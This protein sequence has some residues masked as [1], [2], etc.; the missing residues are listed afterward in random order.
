M[1]EGVGGVQGE[2]ALIWRDGLVPLVGAFVG[3][4]EFEIP[5]GAGGAVSCEERRELADAFFQIAALL[6]LGDGEVETVF[7]SFVEGGGVVGY[8]GAAVGGLGGF[9]VFSARGE[10][11]T[12]GFA[13]LDEM[14]GDGDV[15]D[16]LAA[17]FGHVAV[18]A[19]F[20]ACVAAGGDLL[21][22]GFTVALAAGGV[23]FL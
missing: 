8:D 18:D 17:A 7:G 12:G 14:V 9:M 21:G 23:L 22:E 11:V 4:G 15:D 5:F 1:G 19:V 13:A 20:G 10:E 6:D 3:L 16:V 2:G